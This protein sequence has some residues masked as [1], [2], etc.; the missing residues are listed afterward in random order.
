MTFEQ[1]YPVILRYSKGDLFLLWKDGGS[2]QDSFAT[3]PAGNLLIAH[4]KEG[5][6]RL[7]KQHGLSLSDEPPH[8]VDI[9]DMNRT[10]SI[11]RPSRYVSENAA[12]KLL[13]CWNML[14]DMA[15]ALGLR[16]SVRD[17]GNE[18][19]IDSLYRRMFHGNNLPAMTPAHSKFRLRLSAQELAQLRAY[20]RNA[21]AQVSVRSRLYE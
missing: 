4:D 11:L 2:Q 1:H 19:E 20:L 21:W 13:E 16:N 12:R 8:I 10:L 7:A 17:S 18:N 5:S 6:V 9:D 14:D 15:R 3:D